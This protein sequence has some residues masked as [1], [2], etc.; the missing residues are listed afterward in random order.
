MWCNTVMNHQKSLINGLQKR[1]VMIFCNGLMADM[2]FFYKAND[3]AC[4]IFDWSFEIACIYVFKGTS[5]KLVCKHS[6]TLGMAG[7]GETFP[8]FW[9]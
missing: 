6:C 3:S 1:M 2:E 5:Y 7:M 8:I 9:G 4:V